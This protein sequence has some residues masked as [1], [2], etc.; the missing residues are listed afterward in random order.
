MTNPK[1]KIEN[2]QSQISRRPEAELMDIAAEAVAYANADFGSVNEAF[3]VCML[4]AVGPA[5][6]LRV[7]DLGT[8]PADIPIRL[9]RHR[10]RWNIV[11]VDAAKAMLDLAAAAVAQ[12]GL[13][14]RIELLQA[15]AKATGLP[16]GQFDVVFSNSILHH[17]SDPEK[18]WLEVRRLGRKGATVFVRDLFRPPDAATAQKI[19]AQHAGGETPLLQQEFH[20]SLLAAY[21]PQEVRDQ[22]HQAGLTGLTVEQVTDRHMDIFGRLE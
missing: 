4:E 17:V 18:F 2:R 7:V 22:L 21:T 11:A 15:D 13:A 8:G 3:V 6:N 19:V 10:P 9:M 16:A 20:R 5:E 12:A 14:D 1:S